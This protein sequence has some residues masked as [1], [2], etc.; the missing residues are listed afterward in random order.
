[1]YFH[2]K[3][4]VDYDRPGAW[5]VWTQGVLSGFRKRS[6]KHCSTQNMKA[7]GPCAFG[8]EYFFLCFFFFFNCK[9]MAAIDPPPGW[10]HF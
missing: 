8:K 7:S 3:S 4:M 2:Y 10:G 9:S 5:P 6:T 1:M